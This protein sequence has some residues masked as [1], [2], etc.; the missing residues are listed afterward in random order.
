MIEVS[1]LTKKYGDHIAVDHLSFRVEKGQIYGFLGPNGAGKSTTMNIITGY[2]AATE[3]TVTIDGK[4][5]QKDPEEAK[6]AIGYLPELPPLYVDMTVREYLDF[7]AELKKVPKKERKQQIDE[8]MEMTQITDMQQR[9]I[10]NLSKGYRQRVGLAQAILGYPEVIILDEPTVGLD[11]KQIIEIRDL[12]RKL[13]ENHTVILSSHILSEV[14]AVCDHIITLSEKVASKVL[15]GESYFSNSLKLGDTGCYA[16]L[17]PLKNT[18]G[19]VVGILAACMPVREVNALYKGIVTGRAIAIL[20]LVAAFCV[21]TFIVVGMISKALLGVV[22][23]LDQI[24]EGKLNFKVP[25]KLLNRSDEVGKSARAVYS[26]VNGF[27]GIIRDIHNSMLDMNEFTGTFTSNFDSIGQSISSVNTAVN[28]IAQGATT[29]AADTQKVSESMNEMSNALG[30]TADSV[31]ALSS[32]AANM[33]ESNATVDSTLKEL[34]EIS[35]HTQQSVD[36]VQEQTNITNESAQAIQAATDIIA[37]IANQTNLLSL[38]ASIEAA[39]AGEMG[40]GFAV[41]A[42]E[43]RG[44]A[45]QSRESA[46]KI[47]SIVENLISNSNQ[48]VQIMNGVVGEIHQQNE[49]LGTTLNVFST[50]NQEVQKVVGEIN[51]ISGELDHIENYKTDVVEKIDGLTEISQN[52]AASTEETAATMDQLAE[53]VEDCRQATTQLNEIAGSLN[54]NAKKFQLG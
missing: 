13:G 44:L 9:L 37:G 21:S 50:L 24:A 28:E 49:K 14:S 25:D 30:R 23:N 54:A 19:T 3:G 18:D 4:D 27:S 8:V 42:E 36:Q 5:V 51:V 47:R 48:S 53:I 29:Q 32:S 16:Y 22:G 52:N 12:I 35:S 33:K 20:I 10:R 26:V 39:R 41:V 31:N 7:V 46:D 2:L 34:L 15:G 1:N 40:R 6:R 38:N 17:A 43:I 11:P 45:D